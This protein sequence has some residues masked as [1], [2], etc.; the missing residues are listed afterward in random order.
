MDGKSLDFP[1][2]LKIL[3]ENKNK[4]FQKPCKKTGDG[5]DLSVPQG[6]G[7]THT[8]HTHGF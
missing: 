8:L 3:L 7:Y 4:T 6:Y 1:E 2:N 5:L